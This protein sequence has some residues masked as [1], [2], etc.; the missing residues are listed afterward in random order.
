MATR[1]TPDRTVRESIEINAGCRPDPANPHT[2]MPLFGDPPGTLGTRVMYGCL[3]PRFRNFTNSAAMFA[4]AKMTVGAPWGTPPWTLTAARAEVLL[5]PQADDRLSDPRALM[6]M[7]DDELPANATSL[8]AY[9]TFTF[10][11]ERL[12]VA[13]EEVRHFIKHY[14]VDAF[15]VATLLVQ[16]APHRAGSG[17]APHVHALIA[18]PRRVTTLGLGEWVPQ[19]A[20]DKAH[21]LIRDAFLEFHPAWPAN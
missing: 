5:P 9:L 16:H 21:A 13:W 2:W 17:N 19:L 15:G 11:T 18:G 20:G 8:L 10:G 6:E 12:H 1:K 14:I 7:V 4:A 3:R